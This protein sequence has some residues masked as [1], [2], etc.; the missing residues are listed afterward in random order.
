[1][2][3]PSRAIFPSPNHD[4]ERCAS[5]AISHAE[6]QCAARA[7]RLTPMRR[8][9]LQTLLA[10]HKPLGAYE[11]IEHWAQKRHPAPITIYRAL[12]FLCENGLVHRIESR[13]AYVAC[14][15][16]HGGGDLVV[17]LIC[18]SCGAVGEAPGGGAAAALNAS[19]RAAGF[20]PKSPLIEIAG[21]CSHCR[22]R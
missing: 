10:S 17:F 19:A 22:K 8:Q 2:A 18:E 5:T 16:N 4:H 7:Q 14:V 11:I 21:V 20:L 1:M 13:N 6:A 12:D 3:N 9:V 15:H